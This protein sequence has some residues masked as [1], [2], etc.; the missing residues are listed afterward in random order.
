MYTFYDDEHVSLHT[1]SS[2]DQ[3]TARTEC[4]E[5]RSQVNLARAAL[6][7][8][9]LQGT[10]ATVKREEDVTSLRDQLVAV[11]AELEAVRRTSAQ[12]SLDKEAAERRVRQVGPLCWRCC[13][14]RRPVCSEALTMHCF[15][16]TLAQ[17]DFSKEEA[18]QA[19]DQIRAQLHQSAVKLDQQS[20]LVVR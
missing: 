18:Q 15:L 2:C 6:A 14:R 11:R 8:A 5:L 10:S 16:I 4:S 19:C 3:V 17:S 13:R 9:E 1:V 7:Q 20:T 12:L